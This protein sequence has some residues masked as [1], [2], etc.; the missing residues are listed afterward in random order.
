MR[1]VG[2][3]KVSLAAVKTRRIGVG[4]GEDVK[5]VVEQIMLLWDDGSPMLWDDGS[6]VV[7]GQKR[8]VPTEPTVLLFDNGDT[9][10]FDD[11]SRVIGGYR[12]VR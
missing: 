3:R 2:L 10:C 1:K 11:D 4:F 12:K 9:V 5:T 8:V 6:N 7:A